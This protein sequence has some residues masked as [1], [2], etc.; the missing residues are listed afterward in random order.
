M[1]A[2]HSYLSIYEAKVALFREMPD[3]SFLRIE[4]LEDMERVV[5][6][7]GFASRPLQFQGQDK[8][9]EHHEDE[10]FVIEMAMPASLTA[11]AGSVVANWPVTTRNG[12]Y[13]MVIV[14]KDVAAGVWWKRVY[15]GVTVSPVRTEADAAGGARSILSNSKRFRAESMED[16]FG[17]GAKPL[18]GVPSRSGV[19]KYRTSTGVVDCYSYNGESFEF[20]EMDGAVAGFVEIDNSVDGE[21]SILLDGEVVFYGNGDGISA[22]GYV[23]GGSYA[24]TYPSVEFWIGGRRAASICADGILYALSF[25]NSNLLAGD[26]M[27]FKSDGTTILKLTTAACS[28]PA[29]AD[30][31]E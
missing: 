11:R 9:E 21:I 16:D 2:P 19:V 1:G 22:K 8:V 27:E 3:G 20:R 30:D 25:T 4:M 18:L 6:S 24:E 13:A 7:G 17:T 12:R 23:S 14:W 29:F 5:M 28:A 26:V 15:R 31:L 10:T